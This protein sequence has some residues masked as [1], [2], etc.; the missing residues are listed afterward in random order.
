MS[1]DPQAL[2]EDTPVMN[3]PVV[4]GTTYMK[5]ESIDLE[6]LSVTRS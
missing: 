4:L 1:R 3:V 5:L 6:E 2:G